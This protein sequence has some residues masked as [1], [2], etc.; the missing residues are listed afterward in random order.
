MTSQL[1]H[2]L[3]GFGVTQNMGTLG[4]LPGL[5]HKGWLWCQ[6]MQSFA[7]FEL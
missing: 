2:L 3:L 4:D 6:D 1:P 7:M 5:A